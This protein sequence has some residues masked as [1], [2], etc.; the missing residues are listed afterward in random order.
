MDLDY[1]KVVNDTYGH[2]A[3]DKVLCSIAEYVNSHLRDYDQIFRYGGEEFLLLLP[4]SSLKTVTKVLNRLRQGIK[5]TVIKIDSG[6]KLNISASF[7]ISELLTEEPTKVSIEQADK[8]LFE[9]KNA[10]RN[11]VTVWQDA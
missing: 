3:G 9:A 2:Q 6:E 10:G 4:N 1:F 8:A 11:K 7:G 5:R